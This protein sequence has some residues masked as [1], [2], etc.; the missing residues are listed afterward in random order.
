MNCGEPEPGSPG[1]TRSLGWSLDEASERGRWKSCLSSW[2]SIK[3]RQK[4]QDGAVDRP[5]TTRTFRANDDAGLTVLPEILLAEDI[6]RLLG[7]SVGAARK[8]IAKGDCGPFARVGRRLVIRREAF[9]ES[10]REREEHPNL[11]QSG[12]LGHTPVLLGLLSK[13]R[14]TSGKAAN[15][16]SRRSPG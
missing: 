14:H 11:A 13:R 16:D 8:L 15:G 1:R 3:A 5:M 2:V 6:A 9:L 4:G 10:L 12:S 7:V